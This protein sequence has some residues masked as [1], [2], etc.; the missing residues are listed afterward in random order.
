ME[1]PLRKRSAQSASSTWLDFQETPEEGMSSSQACNSSNRWWSI[2]K[3]GSEGWSR[4]ARTL[5]RHDGR[6]TRLSIKAKLTGFTSRQSP[7]Q[8]QGVLFPCLSVIN[9]GSV[10]WPR[11]HERASDVQEPLSSRLAY[12]G[13]RRAPSAVANHTK[14]STYKAMSCI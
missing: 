11:R 4:G 13:H 8:A 7:F 3:G 5:A 10:T 6:L 12:H 2:A 1:Q 14:R 9:G